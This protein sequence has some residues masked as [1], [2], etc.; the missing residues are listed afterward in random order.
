MEMKDEDVKDMER[1]SR[2][3]FD[4]SV[5]AL[6]AATRSRLARA[7]AR[8]LEEFRRRRVPGP[9]F[10]LPAGAAA[11]AIAAALLWQREEAAAPRL[12]EA[13]PFEFEDLELVAGGEEFEMLSEDDG[14]YAWAEEQMTDGIG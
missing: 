9:A 14:F 6:D 11:A 12:A 1:R 10:W 3:A 4:A 8:A 2:S 13:A 5:E 7:R